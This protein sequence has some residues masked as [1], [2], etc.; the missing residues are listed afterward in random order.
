MASTDDMYLVM[1]SLYSSAEA[2][3]E[4]MST[5]RKNAIQS[6]WISKTF[7]GGVLGLSFSIAIA[8]LIV[9]FGQHYVELSLIKLAGMWAIP[10]LW[11]PI[12]FVTYYIPK[13]K[14][15]LCILVT[16]NVIAYMALFIFREP[17]V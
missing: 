9:V 4:L 14:T 11:M 1:L 2:E 13:G 16:V 12:F 8:N 15:A 7:A 10:W 5:H 17:S 6:D 3:Y